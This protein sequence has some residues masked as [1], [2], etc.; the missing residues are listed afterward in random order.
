MR[1]KLSVP[2]TDCRDE[3][4]AAPELKLGRAHR[5]LLGALPEHQRAL[6]SSYDRCD[7][8]EQRHAW[9]SDTAA[10][11]VSSAVPL[12]EPTHELLPTRARCPLCAEVGTSQ[13][14]DGFTLPVGLRRHL[15]GHGQ[16]LRCPF[17]DAAIRL[18]YD[19]WE[20]EFSELDAARNAGARA[21]IAARLATERLYQTSPGGP[22]LLNDALPISAT[23]RSADELVWATSRLRELGFAAEEVDRTTSFS[24]RYGRNLILADPRHRGRIIFRVFCAE[25]N[26]APVAPKAESDAIAS[27]DLRDSSARDIKEKFRKSASK[28]VAYARRD[29][30]S[31]GP[32]APRRAQ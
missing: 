3:L 16:Q 7:A 23:P 28:A 24:R 17:M 11:I 9:I 32:S 8:I 13:W 12:G 15:I 21:G 26:S 27:F 6:L 14:G 20:R 19:F 4:I 5:D 25:S 1:S 29:V 30:H 31:H 18:A 22:G 2:T 10:T